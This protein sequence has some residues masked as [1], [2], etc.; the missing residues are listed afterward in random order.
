MPA[1]CFPGFSRF[2]F[3]A[4]VV[5]SLITDEKTEVDT[6]GHFLGL[7]T[8]GTLISNQGQ[9]T[10]VRWPIARFEAALTFGCNSRVVPFFSPPVK[11][12]FTITTKGPKAVSNARSIVGKLRPL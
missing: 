5:G 12:P 9:V 8:Q 7:L 1:K 2:I 10:C 4:D 3:S 11:Q 6:F